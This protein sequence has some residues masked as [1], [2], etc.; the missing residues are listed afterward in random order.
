[1]ARDLSYIF[2]PSIAQVGTTTPKW[3]DDVI[4]NIDVRIWRGGN[5]V[6][7]MLYAFLDQETIVITTRE[8]TFA[9]VVRRFQTPRAKLENL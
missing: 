8:Q 4:K 9:E 1:M 3:Q 5:E 6:V 2:Y 7:I